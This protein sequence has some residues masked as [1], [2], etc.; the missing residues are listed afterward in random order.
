MFMNNVLKKCNLCPRNCLVDR[1]KTTGIC[2]MKDKLVV[3]KAYL[4]EWEEPCIS[5]TNGSGTIFLSGCSLDCVF[6]QNYKISKQPVG[7]TYSPFELSEEIKKLESLGV[8]NVN[9]VTPTHFSDLIIETLDI[10]R[11]SIPIVYNTS[12]YELPSIIEKLNDYVDVYLVDMKYSDNEI[13][14]KFSNVNNYVDF[15]RNSIEVMV[16]NKPLLYDENGLLKQGVIIRHLVLPDNL[17]N[18]YGV[19]DFFADNYKDKAL[20]SVMSQFVPMYNS[21]ITR[22]L[23]PIEYKLVTNYIL[24][25]DIEDCFIQELSSAVDT[26]TPD[27]DTNF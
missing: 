16:K 20:F 18:T 6:C 10:Y 8:H 11:P 26:Y 12:G 22:T 14:K 24:K 23:K 3:A 2:G 21:S 13:A 27:F 15:C 25:R 5:G 19:I 17:K 9:F 7:K 4:H 1:T